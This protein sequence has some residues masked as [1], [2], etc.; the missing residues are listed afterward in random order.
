MTLPETW[1]DESVSDLE[2]C[3]ESS[4]ITIFR[5]EGVVVLL[6]SCQIMYVFVFVL[7]FLQEMLSHA[8]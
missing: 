5:T 3:P 4:D 6:L 7:I 8:G 1:L 2:I